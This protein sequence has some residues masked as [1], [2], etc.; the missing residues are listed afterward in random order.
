MKTISIPE[1]PL[2]KKKVGI[3]IVSKNSIPDDYT[4]YNKMIAWYHNW[5][6]CFDRSWLF[7]SKYFYLICNY[8]TIF[9]FDNIV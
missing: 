6:S 1:P 5:Q 8:Q 9:W 2:F 3:D 4:T 7:K